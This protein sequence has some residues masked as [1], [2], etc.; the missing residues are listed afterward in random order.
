ML[1][2]ALFV[3]L[4]FLLVANTVVLAE[5]AEFRFSNWPL[6]GFEKRPILTPFSNSHFGVDVAGNE[7]EDVKAAADGKVYWTYSGGSNGISVGIEHLNGWRTTYLHLSERLVKKGQEVKAN[8][9]I[10]KVGRTGSGRDAEETH[11]HFALIVDPKSGIEDSAKRY[12]NPLLYAPLTITNEPPK[13]EEEPVPVPGPQQQPAPEI[14][15]E[16]AAQIPVAAPVVLPLPAVL[17]LPV[18]VPIR[19]PAAE[20][21]KKSTQHHVLKTAKQKI[22]K[23]EPQTAQKAAVHQNHLAERKKIPVQPL[24]EA[25]AA[26]SKTF[27][28]TKPHTKAKSEINGIISPVEPAI[29]QPVSSNKEIIVFYWLLLIVAVVLAEGW[30]RKEGSRAARRLPV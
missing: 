5:E 30:R 9:L 1:K 7:G 13:K 24:K 4:I 28:P 25:Q 22:S 20:L 14:P 19:I 8:D 6:E 21:A 26:M 10:G 12:A 15:L 23:I 11:L 18:L 2:R 17:S 29:H 16:P 3:L 27:A